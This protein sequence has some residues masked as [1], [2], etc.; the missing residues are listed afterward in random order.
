[1]ERYDTAWACRYRSLWSRL[2]KWR[3]L[4]LNPANRE[5]RL[6]PY[7]RERLL[8]VVGSQLEPARL[9]MGH[10]ELTVMETL[11]E[12]GKGNV[13]D[14]VCWL[15][16]PLAYNTVMTTLDRLYKKGLLDRSKQERAYLYAPRLSRLDWQQKQ[17]RELISGFLGG[18]G[19]AS[20]LLVSCLVDAVGRHDAALLDDLEEK[21][22]KKRRELDGGGQK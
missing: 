6:G 9:N 22:R 7:Q 5:D 18:Q 13:H 16:R 10:L 1:M 20:E 17:A 4:L 8:A 2:G 12:R 3:G 15:D 21:I 14:V 11:W 19:H